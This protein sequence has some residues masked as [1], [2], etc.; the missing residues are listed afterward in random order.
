ML[1]SRDYYFVLFLLFFFSF[2]FI[3][4]LVLLSPFKF[5]LI[6]CCIC[7]FISYFCYCIY[8]QFISLFRVIPWARNVGK[9]PVVSFLFSSRHIWKDVLLTFY[10]LHVLLI[11]NFFSRLL[12]LLVYRKF[13]NYH[14]ISCI[15]APARLLGWS[16][17]QKQLTTEC[18]LLFL[19]IS[20]S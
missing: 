1:F 20:P 15:K 17:V 13:S 4:L 10:F 2:C 18:P 19:Q 6:L 7:C 5:C 16:F 14:F 9:R 11:F 12:Y 3:F 8:Y